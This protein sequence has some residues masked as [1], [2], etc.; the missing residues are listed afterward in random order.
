MA[1][2]V[3]CYFGQMNIHVEEQH[4]LSQQMMS[5]TFEKMLFPESEQ[6][7]HLCGAIKRRVLLA[8]YEAFL[9]RKLGGKTS[10]ISGLSQA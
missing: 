5:C 10:F 1:G 3:Q 6:L 9:G 4:F 7:Y 2:K 8:L